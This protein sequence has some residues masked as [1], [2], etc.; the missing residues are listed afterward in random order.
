MKK[1]HI[2]LILFILAFKADSQWIS[3]YMGNPIGDVSLSN[4]HGIS[5]TVDNNGYCY[6]TGYVDENNG[7]GNNVLTIK[8]NSSSGDTLWVRTFNG[9]DNNDDRGKDIK[10]DAFGNVYVTGSV[11]NIN[12]GIDAVLLKYSPDGVL[13]WNTS[14][15]GNQNINAE[16]VGNA[17]ALDSWGNIY[18]TGYCTNPDMLNDIILVKYSSSGSQ[19]WVKKEDGPSDLLS[20][21]VNIA[22][23]SYGYNIYVL[24][25][26]TGDQ[27]QGDIALVRYTFWGYQYPVKYINGPVNSEDRAFG[28]AV[29]ANNNVYI[30]GY[31]TTDSV[32][33]NTD[34]ITTKFNNYGNVVWSVSYN[35]EGSDRAFGIAV[36][37]D[38]S[39]YITGYTTNS[40]GTKDYLTVAY[41]NSGQ[42]K[43]FAVYNGPGSGDDKASAIGIVT[44]SNNTKSVIV[45]GSSWGLNNN[46]DYATLNYD[47]AD[48]T[49]QSESRY[50]MTEETEDIANDLVI[51]NDNNA[52]I[53]GYSQ[54]LG[55]LQTTGSA[56]STLKIVPASGGKSVTNNG[57]P[58]KYT[59]SQNYPN[60][61]NPSTTI[62]FTLPENSNVKLC[63][64]DVTGRIVSTLINEYLNSGTYEIKF[65][66]QGIS[67]GVYFYE[68]R[69]NSYRDIKK[70]TLI[71]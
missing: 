55:D 45:T 20:Q 31:I 65:N 35:G 37:E 68:L 57:L 56:V 41:N 5:V 58:S 24:G 46:D 25:F 32:S 10:V 17:I 39:A 28:I 70:M 11:I 33:G 1:Y 15:S 53:T 9:T 38:G 71:K 30:T 36:D 42:Q 40:Y 61:F 2:I 22:V 18:M 44:N 21:G 23:D 27:T 67:S 26:I 50:S 13:L 6:I 63:I 7:E 48:G 16:D 51:D 60:P 52:F 12:T 43:W 62:K 66:A 59:L 54:L 3:N 64:Y 19:L 47:I 49:L 34:C 8:Y 14:Y 29:D 69:A 4:A